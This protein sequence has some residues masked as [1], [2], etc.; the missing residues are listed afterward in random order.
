MKELAVVILI[1][2]VTA[3]WMFRWE[4]QASPSDA[5]YIKL[6]R[7]TGGSYLCNATQ[8]FEGEYVD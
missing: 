6:N 4:I 7:L 2:T 1:G 5:L 3:I 8:C